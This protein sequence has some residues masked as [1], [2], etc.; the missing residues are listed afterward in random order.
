MTGVVESSHQ[1]EEPGDSSR[2]GLPFYGSMESMQTIPFRSCDP[3]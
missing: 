1:P 3:S 2:A